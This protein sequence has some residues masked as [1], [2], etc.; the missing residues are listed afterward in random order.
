[1]KPRL[2]H[3]DV[4]KG[5]A[6]FMVVMGHTL[7]VCMDG[8]RGCVPARLIAGIHMPLFFFIS[9]WFTAKADSD[10]RLITPDLKRRF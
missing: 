2:Y 10:G 5:I 9:G 8:M 7:I 1:M 6:I 4:L 3:F